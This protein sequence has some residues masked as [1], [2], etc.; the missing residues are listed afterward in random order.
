[1]AIA[2]PDKQARTAHDAQLA[3]FGRLTDAAQWLA[4]CQGAAP[5]REP[6]RIRAVIFAEQETPLPAAETAARRAEAGLNVVTLT[7]YSQAYNLGA[8]TAD[9]EIDA[10]ADLLIPG[11][12]E[13]A[14]VPAVVMATM[15]QTEPV[16]IV[17]KQ[18]SV[19]DWKREVCACLLYT[20]DAADE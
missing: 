9:A 1:M 18:R 7:D 8:A 6:Q 10:G 17:G 13:R 4:A 15:T 20:S 16:V 2:Q 5:A 12:E 11:G 3:P 14:R 19:E